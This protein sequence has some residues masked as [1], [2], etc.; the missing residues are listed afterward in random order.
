MKHLFLVLCIAATAFISCKSDQQK[1]TIEPE[2]VSNPAS[3][4]PA[5]ADTSLLPKFDFESDN[6]EFGSITEGEIVSYNFKFK[7]SGKAPLIIT[8][9]SASCGCTVPE[10]SKDP[11]A[12]GQEGFIK[13]TFNSEGKHGMTSKTITLLA[14]T[15]PN[16]K[17]LTIS[18]DIS[19][20]DK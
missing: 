11:I 18:A 1:K 15:I 6:H 19:K 16:T 12:P 10:Y 14:N 20:K 3:A 9:A 8:Q 2:M 13:V 7:N 4:E 17:V 5:N